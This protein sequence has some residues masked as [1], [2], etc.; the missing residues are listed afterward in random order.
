MR[1]ALALGL[2]LF[3]AQ[4]EARIKELIQELDSAS[5]EERDAAY[6]ELVKIGAPAVAGLKKAA[7][8]SDSAEVRTRA[9]DAI[10]AIDLNEKT[11]TVYSEP[12]RITLDHDGTVKVAL[13]EIAKQAGVKIETGGAGVDAKVALKLT[14]A[15]LF[16][17]LDR[18]C[19]GRDDCTWE[20]ADAGGVKMLKDKHVPFPAGYTGPFRVRL[21]TL[22][23]ERRS[24]FKT[25]TAYVTFTAE[26]DFERYLKP[27]GKP[28][29]EFSSATDDGG[30]AVEIKGAEDGGNA[31]LNGV[32]MKMLLN[33][34]GQAETNDFGGS[35]SSEAK[36]IATLK[37]S[38]TVRFPLSAREITFD[39]P[40]IGDSQEAGDYKVRIKGR[41][42][43]GYTL[44]FTKAREDG[45]DPGEELERRFDTSSIVF[46]DKDG[47]EVKAESA[48]PQNDGMQI[49]INGNGQ[50]MQKGGFT[51]RVSFPEFKGREIKTLKFKFVDQTLEKKF[52]FE[53]KDVKLP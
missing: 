20:H 23:V 10:R 4:D 37:G 25:T 41:H 49:V 5:V 1:F 31:V 14:N 19:A 6:Q 39:A 27:M 26:A 7:D 15:T 22:A 50:V 53:I 43:E 11:K 21:T 38:M 16:E 9:Q 35:F 36:S 30:R 34:M 46:V 47:K 32:R 40:A 18:L 52:E 45:T 33:G 17:A 3:F 2:L 48:V 13:E 12:K 28:R 42:K 24:D 44:A 51:Y 8:A 29:I